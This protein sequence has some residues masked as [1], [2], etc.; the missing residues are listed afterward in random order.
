MILSFAKDSTE[1]IVHCADQSGWTARSLPIIQTALTVL[2]IALVTWLTLFTFRRTERQ[3]SEERRAAFFHALILDGGLG[4][5]RDT[6]DHIGTK[7]QQA[8]NEL[9]S[10]RAHWLAARISAFISETMIDYSVNLST[11]MR[12]FALRVHVMDAALAQALSKHCD[13]LENAVTNWFETAASRQGYDS[14]ASLKEIL[15]HGENEIYR[16]LH[17]YEFNSKA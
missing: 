15:V 5:L 2:Q 17:D 3:K 8:A 11:A 6:F 4:K 12:M 7:L 14:C 1:I 16:L 10:H 13:D 9:D